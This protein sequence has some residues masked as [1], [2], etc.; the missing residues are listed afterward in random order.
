MVIKGQ[1]TRNRQEGGGGAL[2]S[3]PLIKWSANLDVFS[4]VSPGW[5]S[6]GIVDAE[7]NARSS[8]IRL[9]FGFCL[10]VNSVLQ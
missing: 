3:A 8:E 4:I 2:I 1:T 10:L 9:R 5:R 7:K 6:I